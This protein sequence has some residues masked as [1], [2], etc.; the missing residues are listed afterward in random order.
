MSAYRAYRNLTVGK[1][2]PI[3]N[4]CRKFGGSTV[5][6][7]SK[8]QCTKS[9]GVA[10]PSFRCTRLHTAYLDHSNCVAVCCS[11][12]VAACCS[13]C[14]AA[15]CSDCVAACCSECVAA[16]CS[17]CVAACCSEC[18][19]A[20]CSNCVAAC[21]S[22][23]VAACCSECVA[24]CC[25]DCVAACCSDT[26]HT[27]DLTEEKFCHVVILCSK[28]GS[29]I[30][31]VCGQSNARSLQESRNLFVSVHACILRIQY[32]LQSWLH[33]VLPCV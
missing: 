8:I 22:E 33:C 29:V 1:I 31:F 18:V 15:C 27:Y 32:V 10:P 17:D 3:I 7:C 25:S 26:A 12:C 20:C 4:S 30:V 2:S 24:A 6:V 19:A 23:C 11:D 16:C 13:E 9:A 28:F 5:F 14:V 21:F